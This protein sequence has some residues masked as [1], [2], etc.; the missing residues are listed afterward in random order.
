MHHQQMECWQKEII[1][2]GTSRFDCNGALVW[3]S[4][5]L[6]EDRTLQDFRLDY[7]IIKMKQHPI[8]V[9]RAA[10]EQAGKASLLLSI[11]NIGHEMS[12]MELDFTLGPY[13]I[14]MSQ[15]RFDAGT[16]QRK[17]HQLA[18][19][20]FLSLWKFYKPQPTV[21]GSYLVWIGLRKQEIN[22]REY[23]LGW[24]LVNEY[25]TVEGRVDC[26]SE[27]RIYFNSALMDFIYPGIEYCEQR[28]F[29]SLE[30][31]ELLTLLRCR[32]PLEWS[33]LI[34]L[35]K[36][37]LAALILEENPLPKT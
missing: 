1:E 24:L 3:S 23:R 6:F 13:V 7:K 28:R 37:K 17:W 2:F 16:L 31:S 25:K 10:L 14:S 15:S 36:W 32:N 21:H 27:L 9:K 19:N 4:K 8:L 20:A 11:R 35:W 22:E 12:K 18:Y 29:S 26:G 5:A 34:D 33:N 30:V